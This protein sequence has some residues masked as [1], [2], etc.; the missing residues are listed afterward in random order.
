[1]KYVTIIND[2]TFEINIEPDG[3]L[4]VNGEK[5]EVDF[6]GLGPSMYSI[7][8]QNISHELTIEQRDGEI[9]VLMRGRLYTSRVL[10]ERALLMAQRSGGLAAE[11]GELNIKSPMP[12]LIVAVRVESGQEIKAGDTIII[13]E[14]MKMQNE[15]KAPRDGVVGTVHVQPGQTVEQNKVLVT[16]G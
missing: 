9:E 1:M 3:S 10:D 16:I 7:L 2:K 8:A 6:R 12:G 14:S 4:T 5:R 11:S 15:L 13:L